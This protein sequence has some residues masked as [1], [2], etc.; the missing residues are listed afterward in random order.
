VSTTTDALKPERL[1]AMTAKSQKPS[2]PLPA[3]SR[4]LSACTRWRTGAALLGVASCAALL[5][6]ST[7]GLSAGEPVILPEGCTVSALGRTALVR[8]DGSFTI[9]SIP[10]NIGSFRVRLVCPDGRTGESVCLT[11]INRGTTVV[12]PLVFGAP[13]PLPLSLSMAAFEP[14]T[15]NPRSVFM[16]QGDEAQLRVTG[17]Y[18]GGGTADVTASPCT[19]YISSNTFYASVAPGGLVRVNNLPLFPSSLVVTALHEGVVAT[20]SFRLE[21]STDIDGDG[22]PNDYE[23]RNFLNPNDPT[24]AALDFDSDG[25]TNFEEFQAGTVPYDPDTD[26]DGLLD[27][28]DPEPL[29]PETAPPTCLITSPMDGSAFLEGESIPVQVDAMDNVSVSR[30][31]FFVDG[32][33]SFTDTFPPFEFPFFAPMGASSVSFGARAFDVAGN[34]ADCA[35]VTVMVMPDPGTTVIGRVLDEAMNLLDGAQVSVLGVSSVTGPDGT[36]SILDVPTTRGDLVVSATFL[37]MDGVT[38]A[39][40][41]VPTAPVRGGTTDA[42]DIVVSESQF[43]TDLGVQLTGCALGC[44][45]DCQFFI[46]LPFTFPLF[47]APEQQVLVTSNG[48][49]LFE[50]FFSGPNFT[51]T[52]SE[53][54]FQRQIAPFWDDLI[55]D[56]TGGG[57]EA[58]VAD[59]GGAGVGGGSLDSDSDGVPDPFDNCPCAFNPD[60]TDTDMDGI[61]DACAKI[62]TPGDSDGD[63]VPDSAD[64]CD[65]VFNPD[66]MDSNQNGIGDAC[67]AQPMPSGLWV[68]DRLPGR[69]VFTWFQVLEYFQV[70]GPSTIQATLHDDGRI[71][72]LYAGVSSLDA[73]VGLSP[74]QEPPAEQGAGAGGGEGS[75]VD[76]SA[77]LAFTSPPGAPIFEQFELPT[78]RGDTDPPGSGLSERDNPFDL[79]GGSITF[80]PNAGGYDV[81][82]TLG[83]GGGGGAGAGKLVRQVVA[84]TVRSAGGKPVP[85]AEVEVRF[86]H[87]PLRPRFVSTGEDGRYTCTGVPEAGMVM[88]RAWRAGQVLGQGAGI[89]GQGPQTVNVE[90]LPVP[91]APGK[92]SATP[93]QPGVQGLRLLRNRHVL[94]R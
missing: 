13:T 58:I 75:P 71:Q 27:G 67:D 72:I 56:C 16:M 29:V 53:F 60:Q 30:V 86:S 11:P 93:V 9:S 49:I 17:N 91:P 81:R 44:S 12:P 73:I 28:E 18:P 33:P 47:G 37:R 64:N 43:E 22:M 87:D 74:G 62:D 68:N 19:I 5:F 36:F 15:Q 84:G 54:L 82:T 63:G 10:S 83:A 23:T 3:G 77:M 70:P 52:V 20:F 48:V 45:D 69:V 94:R 14:G 42:G 55:S 59:G 6:L 92:F 26:R 35:P 90:V 88:A 46:P 41:S 4:T 25:L 7:G 66:Q 21:P 2:P 24:D 80:T 31:D 85:G 78:P 38:L 57:G 61:G 1:L 39:G 32:V 76:Y 40:S 34:R 79:D 65:C 8:T 50:P 51:E 89:A